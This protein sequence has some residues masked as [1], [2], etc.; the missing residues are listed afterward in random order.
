MEK[1]LIL[2]ASR[3]GHTRVIVDRIAAALADDFV[4]DVRDVRADPPANL[5]DY[6]AAIIGSP[7]LYGHFHKPIRRFVATHAQQL[8]DMPSAFFGINL[9]ARKP[10][11]RT[12]ETNPYVRKFLSKSPWKP[13]CVGVFAGALYYPR[14]NWLDRAAI[15]LIMRITG[16]EVDPNKEVVYTDWQSVEN[17]AADCAAAFTSAQRQKAQEKR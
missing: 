3:F 2:Y 17:F 5:S 15:R 4:C 8:N 6:Q 13:A 9:V 11:K 14:Y 1:L 12:A 10:A 7:I 16:G